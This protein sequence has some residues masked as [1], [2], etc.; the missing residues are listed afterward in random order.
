[1]FYL[2]TTFSLSYGRAPVEPGAGQLSGLGYSY[3]SFVLMLIV[4]VVF[5]GIFTLISG[6][7]ADRWGRRKT[8]IMVTLGIIII[9][10]LW[11]PL[12]SMGVGGLMAWLALGFRLMRMSFGPMGA[13][14][15]ALLPTNVRYT[16][17]GISSRVA[18]I[19]GGAGA[20]F[21]AL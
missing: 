5:F 20:H 16:G 4:G 6:P 7:L 17:A 9:S 18:S 11:V 19:R 21:I 1:L 10:L 2:M 12:L 14:L 15:A 3:N 13:V 8:L